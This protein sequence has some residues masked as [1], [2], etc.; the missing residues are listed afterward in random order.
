MRVLVTNDDGVH[1]PGL[2]VAE[3]IA[4]AVGDEIWVV[5]PETDQSGLAHSLS[6]NDPL[7]LRKIGGRRFAV[8]GTPTD[9]IIM[10]IRQLMDEPPDL[11]LS[12][13]NSGQNLA[14]DVTYSGT[15][16]GAIEGTLLGIPSIALSQVF[17]FD[18]D[19]RQVPWETAE[20]HGPDVIGTLL[21]F[22]F[23]DGVFYN[24]NFPN[25]PPAEI[26]GTRITVQGS[27]THALHTDE[28]IDGRGNRYFWLAYQR[29]EPEI[30]PGTDL[31]AMIH[32]AVSITPLR[33]D[34]T[35]HG[36]VEKLERHFAQTVPVADD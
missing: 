29:K 5:A 11:V 20:Q 25:R 7:R 23:P 14:D 4:E 19:D 13:V 16:A 21:D 26:T 31:E 1:G 6:L 24:V 34:L 9:C 18:G 27:R 17:Q 36:L 35:A 32:G 8:R 22:G 28:R 30:K 15:V 3:R 2:A 10:A 33:L 12:G